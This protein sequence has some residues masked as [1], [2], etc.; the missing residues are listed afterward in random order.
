M[1]KF[2]ELSDEERQ[3]YYDLVTDI[4]GDSYYCARVWEAWYY[5]TMTQDDFSLMGED[6][7][8]VAEK[9]EMLYYK[10]QLNNQPK[11]IVFPEL[12]VCENG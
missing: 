3:K 2:E 6:D 8:Y 11:E 9:A 5:G 10:M 4:L 7:C 12:V 1:I